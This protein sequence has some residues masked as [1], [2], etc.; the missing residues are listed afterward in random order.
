MFARLTAVLQVH[1]VGTTLYFLVHFQGRQGQSRFLFVSVRTAGFSAAGEY[2]LCGLHAHCEHIFFP[3]AHLTHRYIERH[4]LF[5]VQTAHFSLCLSQSGVHLH[6]LHKKH[7]PSFKLREKG[8]QRT[9]LKSK[10]NVQF[11]GFTGPALAHFFLPPQVPSGFNSI[12]MSYQRGR[13]AA[14][15][16]MQTQKACWQLRQMAEPMIIQKVK[17]V[18]GAKCRCTVGQKKPK[19][20]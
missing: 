4:W 14:A 9:V 5:L 16:Q 18:A 6:L 12:C 7:L 1:R 8:H 3:R 17:T 2:W 19:T 10:F 15:G 11:K 13:V 20:K